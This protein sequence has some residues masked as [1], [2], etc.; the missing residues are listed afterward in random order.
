MKLAV[1]VMVLLIAAARSANL[2]VVSG[3]TCN[4]DIATDKKTAGYIGAALTELAG[5]TSVKGGGHNKTRNIPDDKSGSISGSASC[6]DGRNF[7]DCITCLGKA[8]GKLLDNCR[9]RTEAAV[10]LGGCQLQYAKIK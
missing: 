9:N 1:A 8:E 4:S 3:P 7:I 6:K 2:D 5:I 10:E